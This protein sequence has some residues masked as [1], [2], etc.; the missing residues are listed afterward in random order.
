MGTIAENIYLFL[1]QSQFFRRFN[2]NSYMGLPEIAVNGFCDT[3]FA[4]NF[5]LVS[6]SF[7]DTVAGQHFTM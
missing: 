3:Q 6:R 1:G 2:P 5:G 7:G 4:N